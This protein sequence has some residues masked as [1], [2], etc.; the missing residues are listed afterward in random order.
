[1]AHLVSRSSLCPHVVKGRDAGLNAPLEANC[2]TDHLY[3]ADITEPSWN[4]TP[5]FLRAHVW[6]QTL[7]RIYRVRTDG[8]RSRF[9]PLESR[10]VMKTRSGREASRER[11]FTLVCAMPQ[12][13]NRASRQIRT[14]KGAGTTTFA[15]R[16]ASRGTMHEWRGCSISS[17]EPEAHRVQKRARAEQEES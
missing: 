16:A 13:G 7:H 6:A 10:L 8:R 11:T 5:I 1:M 4:V 2:G 14:G 12:N 9:L 17:V 3:V 15:G